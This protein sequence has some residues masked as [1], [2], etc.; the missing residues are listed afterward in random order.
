[1]SKSIVLQAELVSKSFRDADLQVDVLKE[2]NLSV[3]SGDMLAIIGASGAGKSTLLHC[4][5]GLDRLTGGD[6]K[7][8][9]ESF[10][11]TSESKRCALRNRYLGFVYQFHHLLPE[12]DTVENI[13]MPLLIAG[14]PMQRAREQALAWLDKVGLSARRKHRVGEL[15]GGERQRVAIARA[16]VT[17]PK[18]VLADEPTGNLDEK[19]AQ[20]IF[21]LMLTLNAEQATS[22][23]VVTHSLALAHKMRQVYELTDGGLVCQSDDTYPINN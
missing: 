19:T 14:E 3:Q 11:T 16:L 13:A 18:C 5:G 8:M 20:G 6:V 17:E 21:D 7:L 2:V 1:M 22:F 15:S 9:G 4:L 12:F 10:S 23:V